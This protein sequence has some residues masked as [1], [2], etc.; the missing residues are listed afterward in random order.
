MNIQQV[1][2]A[3]IIVEYEGKKIL[4]LIP[5]VGILEGRNQGELGAREGRGQ[6]RIPAMLRILI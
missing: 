2:N 6:L 3:T 4:R 1:R 5:L